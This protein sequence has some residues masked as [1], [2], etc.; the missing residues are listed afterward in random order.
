MTVMLDY[1]QGQKIRIEQELEPQIP[2]GRK[3][4]QLS[5]AF[6]KEEAKKL[7]GVLLTSIQQGAE[8]GIAVQQRAIDAEGLSLDWTLV[9]TDAA[10]WA[11]V[12]AGELVKK[13]TDTTKKRVGAQVANWYEQA[14]RTFPELVQMIAED[15]AFNRARARLIAMTESTRA[16]VE[17]ELMAAG[18]MEDAG[19]YEYV[20]RWGTARDDKVCAICGPMDNTKVMGVRGLFKLPNGDKKEGPP[21]HPGCRCGVSM[22]PRVPK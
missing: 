15:P 3:A 22:I 9:N 10:N 8:N 7:L 11:R 16:H 1:W 5:F 21:A 14:D 4:V 13:V 12:Y 19:F 20:K 18:H 6:W 17:G 2:E